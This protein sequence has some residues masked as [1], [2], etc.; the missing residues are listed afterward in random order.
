MYIVRLLLGLLLAFAVPHAW[1]NAPRL[2]V[3][4]CG[5]IRH[6]DIT[7]YGLKNTDT[8]VRELFVPCYLIENGKQRLLWD[9]GLPLAYVGR[10]NFEV[11]EGA[12]V[13]YEVSLID[14]LAAMGLSPDDIDYIAFSHFHLDHVGAGN[15]FVNS[16]LL[17]QKTEHEAAFEHAEDNEIFDPTLY[18]KLADAETTLLNGDHDVF[19][20]GSV[21]II[22]APGHTPGHQVL[23]LELANTGRIVLSGDLY[24]FEKSRELGAVPEFNTDP[25]QTRQSFV[26]VDHLLNETGATLWIEH[27]KALADS[28][29]KAPAFYD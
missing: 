20:D 12:Y 22:S 16:H 25:E 3:F 13:T 29:K 8:D 27:S 10:T 5:L 26:R 18:D 24:H 1:S 23:Y 15:A 9:G 19:G 11:L 4:D 14:Q 17:I 28:L 21:V 6:D 2:Y 7:N